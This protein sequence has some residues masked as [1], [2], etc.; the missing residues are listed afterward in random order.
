MRHGCV[1]WIDG[2]A[3]AAAISVSS[4]P[5]S[6]FRVCMRG[7]STPVRGRAVGT[8]PH[9]SSPLGRRRLPARRTG[10]G[11]DHS[12]TLLF[13]VPAPTVPLGISAG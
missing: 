8:A 10:L 7:S 1:L 5:A 6:I 4:A 13:P 2:A 9:R 3:T 11:T 12:D